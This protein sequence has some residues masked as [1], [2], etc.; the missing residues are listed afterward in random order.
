[1]LLLARGYFIL[2]WAAR[3]KYNLIS[4][5]SLDPKLSLRDLQGYENDPYYCMEFLKEM[6]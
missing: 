5:C 6:M 2:R 3:D 1:M 4:V